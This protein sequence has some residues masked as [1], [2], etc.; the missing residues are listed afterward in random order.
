MNEHMIVTIKKEILC[1]TTIFLQNVGK[2]L[3]AHI[4]T[5]PR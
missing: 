2:L 5:H 1:L 4:A 3:P